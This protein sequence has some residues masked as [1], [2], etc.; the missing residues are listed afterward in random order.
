MTGESDELKK[1]PLEHCLHKR[2]EKLAELGDK[3][4]HAHDVTTPVLLSGTQIATGEG[5]FM[6]VVVGKYSCNGKIQAKLEQ[7]SDEMTPLQV[8]LE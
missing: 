6:A 2:Q 8:K 5:W 1:E 4:G 3:K 7:N